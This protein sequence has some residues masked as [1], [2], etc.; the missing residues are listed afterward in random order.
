MGKF[1]NITQVAANMTVLGYGQHRAGVWTQGCAIGCPGCVSLH[2]HDPAAGR[3]VEPAQ[4]IAW[5]RNHGSPIDGLTISGGEPSS[6]DSVVRELIDAYRN[7]FPGDVLL[8][9]G[10]P[11]TNFSVRYPDL[12]KACDVVIAGPYVQYLPA[13]PLRG[14]SNQ[15]VHLLTELAHERY[16]DFEQWPVHATQ[17]AFGDSKITT[18]GIPNVPKLSRQLTNKNLAAANVSWLPTQTIEKV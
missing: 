13:L 5:L 3:L 7:T 11:W 18:V 12:A 16:W 10:L 2:T 8:Y 9:T 17:A 1:L 6:Q 14:S 4:I 15:T